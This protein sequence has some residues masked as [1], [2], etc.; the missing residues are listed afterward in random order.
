MSQPGKTT[1]SAAPP[2][3]IGSLSVEAFAPYV[4]QAFE[5]IAAGDVVVPLV[6]EKAEAKPQFT[7]PNARRTSFSLMFSGPLEGPWLD[8]MGGYILRHPDAGT[9]PPLLMSRVMPPPG[10]KQAAYY[11]LVCG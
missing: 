2:K 4:G 6:L 10:G 3:D 7:L 1:D 8:G 11:Q 9:F 5:A